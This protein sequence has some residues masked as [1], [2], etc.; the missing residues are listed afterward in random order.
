ML[1]RLSQLTSLFLAAACWLFAMAGANAADW[2]KASDWIGLDVLTAEGERLGQVEDFALSLES[3][4]IHYVVISV[5]SFLIKDS[6]IAVDPKALRPGQTG[7]LTLHGV[8]PA[9]AVRFSA[10]SWPAESNLRVAATDPG[11]SFPGAQISSEGLT[12]SEDTAEALPVGGSATISSA[13]RR[14]TLSASERKIESIVPSVA[15]R[16]TTNDSTAR[17]TRNSAAPVAPALIGFDRIDGDDDGRLNRREIGPW[18]RASDGFADVDLDANGHIDRF[19]FDVF[20]QA[21]K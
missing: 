5:G 14:A 7:T 20:A 8:N 3:G 6:L 21:R 16:V 1:R 4:S 18:L 13:R 19:E 11:A 17:S 12:A 9:E 2:Q 15:P 10:D